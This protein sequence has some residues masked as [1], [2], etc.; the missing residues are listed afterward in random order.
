MKLEKTEELFSFVCLH[1]N[2]IF[3]GLSFVLFVVGLFN[4]VPFPIYKCGEYSYITFYE[5]LYSLCFTFSA[6]FL[7][8]GFALRL[9]LFADT[10]FE[11]KSSSMMLCSSLPLLTVAA[12]LFFYREVIAEIPVYVWVEVHPHTWEEITMIQ[13]DYNYPYLWLS[14]VLGSIGIGCL[15]FGLFLKL[16]RII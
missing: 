12:L 14:P 15:L 16:R 9:E 4:L 5:K 3:I 8:V 10:K 2:T 6:I 11:E 7:V 13:L 1:L